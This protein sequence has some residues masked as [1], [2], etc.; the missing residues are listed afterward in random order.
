LEF[1]LIPEASGPKLVDGQPWQRD[2]RFA[3]FRS[4]RRH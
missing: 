1:D 4:K 3:E 2:R